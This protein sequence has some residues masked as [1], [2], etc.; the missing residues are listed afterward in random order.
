M[1]SPRCTTSCGRGSNRETRRARM[2]ETTASGARLD[3]E[4][5]R[6]GLARSRA[7]AVAAITEGLVTVDGEPARKAALQVGPDAV[8]EIAGA[9]HYVSRGAHKLIAA[10]DAFGVDPAGRVAPHAG[11]STRGVTP[12]L[13][14]RGAARVV[15][16][17]LRPGPPVAEKAEDPARA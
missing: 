6:R 8:L 10:L 17:H 3:A 7:M 15:A 4:L 1:P 2:P 12:A 14:E 16:L 9:D 11:G 5:V 13:P